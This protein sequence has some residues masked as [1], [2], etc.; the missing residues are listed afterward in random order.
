MG[1][2]RAPLEGALPAVEIESFSE[3]KVTRARAARATVEFRPPG[4]EFIERLRRKYYVAIGAYR[5]FHPR[6]QSTVEHR[7][8]LRADTVI[9]VLAGDGKGF[10]YDSSGHEY[11]APFDLRLAWSWPALPMWLSVG[12]MSS[13]KSALRLS[14][15]SRRRLRYPA[16]YFDAAHAALQ[17]LESRLGARPSRT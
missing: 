12:E 15:R 13:T 17:E 1:P 10:V 16:R 2:R 5:D 11:R 8:G 9:D 6:L 14:L 4:Y 3:A 7:V